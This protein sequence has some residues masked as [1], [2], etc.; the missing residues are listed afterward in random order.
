M[1]KQDELEQE[2]SAPINDSQMVDGEVDGDREI[3]PEQGI[4]RRRRRSKTLPAKFAD[5]DMS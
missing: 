2:L 4:I 5:Y 1:A 3:M